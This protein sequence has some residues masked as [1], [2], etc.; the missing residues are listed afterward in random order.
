M[1]RFIESALLSSAISL[2]AI[3]SGGEQTAHPVR[4]VAEALI[5]EQT[6]L[7]GVGQCTLGEVVDTGER[8]RSLGDDYDRAVL[9][10]PVSIDNTD[11]R[12][13]ALERQRFNGSFATFSEIYATTDNRDANGKTCD[14]DSGF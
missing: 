2:S 4:G 8:Y 1:K 14:S 7:R 12:D 3:N 11:A 6:V 13:K 9:K 10:V 5:D